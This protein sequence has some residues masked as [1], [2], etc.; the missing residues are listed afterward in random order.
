M[1]NSPYKNALT[2]EFGLPL[3][4][5]LIREKYIEGNYQTRTIESV[6]LL[7]NEVILIV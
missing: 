4:S 1:N 3:S 2:F 6:F 5:Y 7:E